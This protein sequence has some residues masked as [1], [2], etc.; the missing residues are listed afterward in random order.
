MMMPKRGQKGFTLIELL[1]VV[2]ILG[3]LAAVVIP[4]VGR[5]FGSGEEEAQNTEYSSIQTAISN[6]MVDN[7]LTD[8]KIPATLENDMT[9]FP[10]LAVCET[11]KLYDVDGAAFA[12]A[13]DG[14]YWSLYGC[15]VIAQGTDLPAARVNYVN[16]ATTAYYYTV[17][18]QGNLIQY[19]DALGN[20][21]LNPAP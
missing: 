19:E 3:I 10:D 7:G 13:G 5:F 6:M 4:N 14:D 18:E 21:Q 20:I 15:D 2:A 1:I 11:G 8:I 12:L 16:M 9:A 17:D